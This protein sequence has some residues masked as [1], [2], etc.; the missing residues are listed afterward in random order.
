MLCSTFQIRE[1]PVMGLLTNTMVSIIGSFPE[2]VIWRIARRYIAGSQIQH[3][4][5]AMEMLAGRDILSTMDILG[6][7]TARD[8]DADS[9]VE[10]YKMLI[11]AI[12]K[13]DVKA[14]ISIK[15]TQMGLNL[16]P[17]N[18][19]DRMM[20]LARAASNAG[21]FLRLDIEDSTTTDQT[22]R[23]YDAIRQA[24]EKSGAAI[25]AYLKRSCEDVDRLSAKGPVNMR[26]CKGIYRE[27]EEIAFH[28]RQKI[29]ENF[30]ELI[31]MVFDRE[32]YPAI[33]THDKW[34]IREALTEIKRRNLQNDQYEFQMLYGVRERMWEELRDAGHRIRIYVPF[35]IAWRA[36]SL[37][38][39]QENPRLAY[40]VIKNFVMPR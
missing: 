14:N 15:P 7:D 27:S 31:R 20:S 34:V 9:S 32:G 35:G 16:D 3:G 2:M 18:A 13:T 37:R 29:R 40:Y 39:F 4:I 1:E 28:N 25:Q 5:E 17:D 8:S 33:A 21:L 30:L 12:S 19:A 24:T 36:Y 6:E 38:R 10:E 23:I 22:F 11:E 26:I